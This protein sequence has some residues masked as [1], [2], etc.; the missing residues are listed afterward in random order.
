MLYTQGIA[1]GV[2]L[3]MLPPHSVKNT[4][5]KNIKIILECDEGS[6]VFICCIFSYDILLALLAFIFAFIARKLEDNFRLGLT[7]HQQ[8]LEHVNI[9]GV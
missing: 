9:M 1:C 6:V 4:S 5:A 7:G 2:W 3:I 8:Y